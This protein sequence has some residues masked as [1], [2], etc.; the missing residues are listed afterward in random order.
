MDETNKNLENK[1]RSIAEKYADLVEKR[2]GEAESMTGNDMT[3]I[4]T[5]IQM[6]DHIVMALERFSRISERR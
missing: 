3:E 1:V 4:Y 6:L 5:C 2:I